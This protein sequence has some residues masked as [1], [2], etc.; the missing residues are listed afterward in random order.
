MT[1]VKEGYYSPCETCQT[2][3]PEDGQVGEGT[4][5]TV[6]LYGRGHLLTPHTP[7][8]PNGFVRRSEPCPNCGT[9]IRNG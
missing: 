2:P 7:D 8:C 9:E 6:G 1:R 3:M 5:T 4:W